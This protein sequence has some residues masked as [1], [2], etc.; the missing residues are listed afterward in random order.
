MDGKVE[1][2]KLMTSQDV[3]I[4][5]LS[6]AYD[7]TPVLHQV[8]VHLRQ[9]TFTSIVGRSGTGKSTLIHALAG[10]IAYTG[11]VSV[12][13]NVGVVLQSHRAGVFPHLTV[14]GNIEIALLSMERRERRTI[15]RQCLEKVGL[16]GLSSRYPHQL[17]GGQ[18]QRVALARALAPDPSLLLLDEPLSA[19]D[20]LT[21]EEMQAW[22]QRMY[23]SSGKTFVCVTHSLEEAVYLSDSILVLDGG[24]I[25]ARV[26]VP[27]SRPRDPAVRFTPE[28]VS[29]REHVASCVFSNTHV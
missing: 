14:A 20:D 21:R 28:F 6:V 25:T 5:E 24:Q 1:E 4:N 13:S 8:S 18:L 19:L 7:G 27:L 16:A 12:P 10:F 9:G 3:R 23:L 15:L 26:S 22:L 29:I 17:S 11:E 2:G